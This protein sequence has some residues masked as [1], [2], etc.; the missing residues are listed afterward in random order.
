MITRKKETKKRT[1]LKC[2]KT[3]EKGIFEISTKRRERDRPKRAKGKLEMR[4]IENM[5][6][7]IQI[8]FNLGSQPCKG[9][10]R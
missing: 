7:V 2:L 10:W 3:K 8:S 1:H 4:T 9:E 6:P 5:R